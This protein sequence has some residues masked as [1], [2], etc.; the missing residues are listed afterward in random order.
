M[1]ASKILYQQGVL[2]K[3]TTYIVL[4]GLSQSKL[5]VPTPYLRTPALRQFLQIIG[6]SQNSNSQDS[7]FMLQREG[8]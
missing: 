7:M 2:A 6:V 1:L 5:A 8:K 4:D 3:D